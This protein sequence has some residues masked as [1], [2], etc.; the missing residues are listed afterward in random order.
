MKKKEYVFK[1][2]NLIK[3]RV[4][5]HAPIEYTGN[6]DFERIARRGIDL[7]LPIFVFEKDMSNELLLSFIEAQK[8]VRFNLIIDRC[9]RTCLK[10]IHNC[11]WV[12]GELLKHIKKLDIN[13]KT[14]SRYKLEKI[15]DFLKIFDQEVYLEEKD[16]HLEGNIVKE[17]III[18]AKKYLLSGECLE[19]NVV[20]TN[21]QAKEISLEYNKNL[22]HGYYCFEKKKKSIKITSLMTNEEIYL[23]LNVEPTF[24][25]FSC[26]TG[27]ESSA[28]A[29]VNFKI[30]EE[31]K[32]YEKRS[33][34]I[35]FGKNLFTLKNQQEMDFFYFL[36][37]KKNCETFDIKIESDNKFFERSFNRY[38]PQKIWKAW[39]DG[40]QDL[41]S[42]NEYVNIKN[43]IVIKEK[44][45][46]KL[47]KS[48]YPITTI[49]GYDGKSYKKIAT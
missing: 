40:K 47:L 45:G 25:N 1:M 22:P 5:Y 44:K 14:N 20:N 12:E 49:Y 7:S 11:F 38:L 2:A 16:F 18:S 28:F 43:S 6:V 15:E 42:E 29:K 48:N 9:D 31:L 13:Y 26:V 10:K 27:V 34:F 30:K 23:N 4:M 36:S 21:K 3:N 39:I 37:Q 33:Y 19:I 32:A 41:E 46:Y 17:G 35:N 24:S 8:Q